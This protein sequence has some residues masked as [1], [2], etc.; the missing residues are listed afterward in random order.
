M[1]NIYFHFPLERIHFY[2]PNVQNKT[3]IKRKQSV[4][5]K[6]LKRSIKWSLTSPLISITRH[7]VLEF[8]SQCC[9]GTWSNQSFSETSA[10]LRKK[11]R[12]QD[13]ETEHRALE[14][15]QKEAP[16]CAKIVILVGHHC[17]GKKLVLLV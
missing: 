17:L 2:N 14:V 12:N 11:K 10:C 13:K 15:S 5:R 3:V 4:H 6:R 9:Q 8:W 1:L 16:S 7:G